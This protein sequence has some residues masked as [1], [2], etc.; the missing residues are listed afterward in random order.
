MHKN[1]AKI[2]SE[3]RVK[4]IHVVDYADCQ[5]ENGDISNTVG[6]AYLTKIHGHSVWQ[7]VV[8]QVGRMYHYSVTHN[9]FYPPQP[10]PTWTLDEA[11]GK[12]DPP[13]AF[14]TAIEYPYT[15]NDESAP[16]HGVTI[17][18]AHAPNWDETNQRWTSLK[19]IPQAQWGTAINI[20]NP[21]TSAWD[22]INL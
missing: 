8:G 10:Y 13:V 12:W 9:L 18:A 3:N 5:D 11:A 16:D 20:W 1:F 6:I 2:D 19:N 21:D 22:L 4:S 14:P 7:P 17:T 15:V